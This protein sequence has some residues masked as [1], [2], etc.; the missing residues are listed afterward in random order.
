MC[1]A[2]LVWILSKRKQGATNVNIVKKK[3]T[4]HFNFNIQSEEENYKPVSFLP[5][6]HRIF[7]K[8]H[9][10]STQERGA[11]I[12][13]FKL[14]DDFSELR[15]TDC[16]AVRKRKHNFEPR[17]WQLQYTD[18]TTIMYELVLNQVISFKWIQAFHSNVSAKMTK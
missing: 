7:K 11:E 3:T 2:S 18:T 17:T 10:K 8:I 6:K 4:K 5:E 9:K 14:R 1:M 16:T 15:V 12:K 13:R